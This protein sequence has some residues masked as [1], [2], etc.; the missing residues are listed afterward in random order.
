M[1]ILTAGVLYIISQDVG[2]NSWGFFILRQL[3][4]EKLC[5]AQCRLDYKY[6]V[7][8]FPMLKMRIAIELAV[9]LPGS[10]VI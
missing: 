9:V 5:S 7:A 2:Y 4:S 3:K 1:C 6:A 8:D 10:Q